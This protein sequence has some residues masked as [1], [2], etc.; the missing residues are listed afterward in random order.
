MRDTDYK[1]IAIASQVRRTN[2]LAARSKQS[3][4]RWADGR[5]MQE[6]QKRKDTVGRELVTFFG[7]VTRRGCRTL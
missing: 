1:G 2:R 6:Q 5:I 7:A 4:K 3:V